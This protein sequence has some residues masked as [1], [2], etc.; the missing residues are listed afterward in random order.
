MR[1]YKQIRT[2]ADLHRIAKWSFLIEMFLAK[3][4]WLLRTKL[5]PKISPSPLL[6]LLLLFFLCFL[7]CFLKDENGTIFGTML[8]VFPYYWYLR[9]RN[10]LLF[11]SILGVKGC[12]ITFLASVYWMPVALLLLFPLNQKCLQTFPIVSRREWRGENCWSNPWC[13]IL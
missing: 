9:A 11:D 8:S 12:L 13:I 5:C 1:S 4:V 3:W 6:L 10:I 7:S 2:H